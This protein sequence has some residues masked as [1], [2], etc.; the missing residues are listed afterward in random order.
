MNYANINEAYNLANYDLDNNKDI[1]TVNLDDNNNNNNNN[2]NLNDN[3]NEN[4]NDKNDNINTIKLLNTYKQL[5]NNLNSNIELIE[6]IDNDKMILFNF[7]SYIYDKHIECLSILNNDLEGQISTK[8]CDE[9]IM[10][11]IEKYNDLYTKWNND[12]YIKKK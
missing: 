9:N 1:Y 10:N 2:N 4:K 11:Y 6:T 5:N 8:E 7:L 12:I 3:I